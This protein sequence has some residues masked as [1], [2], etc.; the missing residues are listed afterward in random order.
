MCKNRTSTASGALR[1]FT[2]VELLVVI[3]I[4]ALLLSVLLPSLRKAKQLAQRVLCMS[5]QKQFGLAHIMYLDENREIYFTAQQFINLAPYL[6]QNSTKEIK[7]IS[8]V[9]TCPGDKKNMSGLL[10]EAWGSPPLSYCSNIYLALQST[11]TDSPWG[12]VKKSDIKLNPARV[13]YLADMYWSKVGTA[14]IDYATPARVRAWLIDTD[15]HGER[16]NMLYFDGHTEP[17]VKKEAIAGAPSNGWLIRPD[18]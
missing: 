2:L 14:Y 8:K 9:F 13:F 15:W 18:E 11:V 6:L 3:A 10:F 16:V 17:I 1:G 4:I 12:R 7:D 5:N